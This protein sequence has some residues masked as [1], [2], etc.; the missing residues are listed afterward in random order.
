[1]PR[2]ASQVC[3][4]RRGR[5]VERE[6]HTSGRLGGRAGRA[7][8]DVGLETAARWGGLGLVRVGARDA[9]WGGVGGL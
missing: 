2:V 7:G 3:A 8:G 6:G 9:A 5:R 4:R 1:M